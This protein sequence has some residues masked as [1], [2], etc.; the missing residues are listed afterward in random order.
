MAIAILQTQE[1]LTHNR[2]GSETIISPPFRSRRN[3]NPQTMRPI[4]RKRSPVGFQENRRDRS[5]DEDQTVV[6]K[7]PANNLVMG[8]VKILKRGEEL[9]LATDRRFR[10]EDFVLSSTDRLGPEPETVQKQIR[11]SDLKVVDGLCSGSALFLDSPP[12]SS[13]PLPAFFA[14]KEKKI[15]VATSDLRRLLRLDLL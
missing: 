14:K 15:D 11:A 4:R 12:P 2:F 6:V 3:P 9:K 1:Y 5:R 7:Y 13:V 10:D 8:Q